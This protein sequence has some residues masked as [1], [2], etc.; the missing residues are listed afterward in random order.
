MYPPLHDLPVLGPPDVRVGDLHPCALGR[1]AHEVTLV[2]APPFAPRG[3]LG[4]LSD[5]VF[6]SER[7][8][9]EWVTEKP[10]GLSKALWRR[11]KGVTMFYV[12]GR[13]ELSEE[14]SSPLLMISSMTLRT[15]VFVYS[16]ETLAL[17]IASSA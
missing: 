11:R 12:G 16:E 2:C 9:G 17:R 13:N 8:I 4:A 10:D 15:R 6:N 5:D 14:S 3:D 1:D 7:Y